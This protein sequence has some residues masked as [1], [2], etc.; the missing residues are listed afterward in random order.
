VSVIEI[1]GLHFSFG[2]PTVLR[3][4]DLNVEQ[5]SLVTVF[6]PNGAGKTTLLKILAGLLRP[7]KGTVVIAGVDADR[8][9]TSL[10]RIIGMISHQPYL[11]PQLTG[12]ENL[13]FYGRLY[14]LADPR[15]Y[16]RRMLEQMGLTA[17]AD[18]EAGTYSRG[19]QQRL[20]AARALLHDPRVLLLDEPFTGL[21]QQGREQLSMLLRGLRDGERTIVMTTHD[22][23][24]GLGLADRV[25][26][27]ARGRV[28]LQTATTGLDHRSFDALYR[29]ACAARQGGPAEQNAAADAQA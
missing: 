2:G 1:A 12:R 7:S 8:A 27:L 3:G 22:I 13:E 19:M 18:V 9:P 11:Y 26:I 16:A 17:A 15:G 29:E 28:A 23:D 20:A 10:R 25:A 6:G 21:D 5:G 4:V 14:G 24:E